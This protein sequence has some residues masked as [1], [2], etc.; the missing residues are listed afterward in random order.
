VCCRRCRQILALSTQILEHEVPSSDSKQSRFG[1][2]SSSRK[3]TTNHSASSNTCFHYFLI[4]PLNWMKDELVG[5]AELEGKLLCPNRKCQNKIGGYNWHGSRC[6]CG[7]WIVPAIQLQT[8]KVDKV[9]MF[10]LP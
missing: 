4:E 3:S 6:S 5:K 8:A 1:K 7:K 2:G 9:Q 10:A